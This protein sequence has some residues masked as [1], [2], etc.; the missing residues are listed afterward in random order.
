MRQQLRPLLLATAATLLVFC[1]SAWFIHAD[2]E[3]PSFDESWYLEVSCTLKRALVEEGPL[4]FAKAYAKSFRF[5]AP[6]ISLVP[7]PAYLVFGISEDAAFISNLASIP[8]TAFFLFLLGRRLFSEEVATIAVIIWLT[9]PLT[10]GLSRRFFVESWL[11][12]FTVATVYHLF[13]SKGLRDRRHMAWSGFHAGLALL[14]KCFSPMFLF[15]SIVETMNSRHAQLGKKWKRGIFE[16][17]RPFFYTATPIV[18][19]WYA[20]NWMTTAAFMVRSA[21]GDI[22]AHYGNGPAWHP[23]NLIRFTKIILAA[24]TSNYYATAA[25]IT[26]IIVLTLKKSKPTEKELAGLKLCVLWTAIPFLLLVSGTANEVRPLL[27]CLP[28]FSIILAWMLLRSLEKIRAKPLALASFFVYPFLAFLL[29]TFPSTFAGASQFIPRTSAWTG[30]PKT[31]GRMGQQEFVDALAQDIRAPSVVALGLEHRYFNA[32]RLATL[33]AC[34]G[35]DLQFVNYG[36]MESKVERIVARLSQKNVDHL[37][38]VEKLPAFGLPEYAVA[39]Q[40]SL[41]HLL[42]SEKLPFKSL[43]KYTLQNGA[44]VHLLQR[45]GQIRMIGRGPH[46]LPTRG[47]L[48]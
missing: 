24:C 18:L 16:D 15:G 32:N 39:A 6:L 37:L 22:G 2:K 42:K 48:E 41:T 5:K 14:T 33:S 4:E 23:S 7:L 8:L 3:P 17:L 21:Y 19:S 9:T 44:I 40:K 26:L 13:A 12:T 38:L 45:T 35:H 43:K 47:K 25:I 1:S 10:F 31:T 28:A 34:G 20:F 11:T 46:A 27:S 30:P 29:Q 36:H